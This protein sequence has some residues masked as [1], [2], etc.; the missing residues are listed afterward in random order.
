MANVCIVFLPAPD[1]LL[2]S[3]KNQHCFLRSGYYRA[4]GLGLS[5]TCTGELLRVGIMNNLSLRRYLNLESR[6][7]K[8]RQELTLDQID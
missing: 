1:I 8:E 7:M 6:R 4:D 2:Q 5:R 3:P